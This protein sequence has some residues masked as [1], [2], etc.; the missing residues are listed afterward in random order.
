MITRPLTYLSEPVLERL[1][2]Q[3]SLHAE[4]Y[5]SGDFNDVALNNGWKIDLKTVT[6]D[7]LKLSKLDGSATTPDVE[8][9]NSL[10]VHGAL[11]GMTRAI[12]RE[13]RVWARLTHMECLE[14]SRSRWLSGLKPEEAEP[15][16]LTHFFAGTLTQARDDNAIARLWWNAEIAKIASPADPERA[17]RLILRRADIRSNFVERSR[18]VSR[19]KLA[20][21]I[22]RIMEAD[23]WVLS[24]EASYREFMKVLNRN[25]GGILFETMDDEEID[26]LLRE[27]SALAQ[28][29]ALQAA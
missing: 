1:R 18:T 13:E 8:V 23:P 2:Q 14:Y 17:L 9:R 26:D 3:V 27:C 25:G 7:E 21:G 10:I 22:V 20:Q 24:T 11:L 12:A 28:G 29:A 4:R 6:L 5:L 15:H 16:I 19:P